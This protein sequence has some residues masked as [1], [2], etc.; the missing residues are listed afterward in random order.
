M[1]GTP[2]LALPRLVFGSSALGNLYQVYDQATKQRLVDEWFARAPGTVCIDS[3]G[4]YGAGL[5]LEEIGNALR[6]RGVPPAGFL[7]SNKLG[8]KRIPLTEKEPQ[9]EP[10][11]W[12]GLSY[13]AVQS[14]SYDG[15]LE[16]WEQGNALLGRPYRADLLSV[17][18][19][20][21]YLAAATNAIDKGA[22]LNDILEAY[23]A[24]GELRDSAETRAIGVGAKDWRIIRDLT[25]VVDLDWVMFAGSL[26]VYSHPDELLE[27]VRSLALRS[28]RVI[29]SAV[30]HSGFLVGGRHFDYREVTT[31]QDSDLLEWRN[32]F[33][34]ICTRHGVIPA[35]AC[36]EF[37]RAPFGVVSVALNTGKPDRVVDNLRAV[38]ATAP[39]AFWRDMVN[40]GLIRYRP[41]ELR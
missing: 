9:F 15:I 1:H 27:L 20:D 3:A 39:S 31:D 13:D 6:V 35:H 22:R 25:A 41:E 21:E 36:V 8:W 29:N 23:R 18:D 10:G 4:K 16:C 26:T 7:L 32:A 38:N 33:T 30:F 24:L 12:K 14:I 34:A 40:E 17:H 19:P 2:P 11:I 28:V 37:A 5:A